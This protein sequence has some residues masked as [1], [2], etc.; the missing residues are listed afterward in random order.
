MSY[1]MNVEQHWHR[2]LRGSWTMEIMEWVI[3]SPPLHLSIYLSVCLSIRLSAC[4]SIYLS[5]HW[6]CTLS[7]IFH[8]KVKVLIYYGFCW[9]TNL[10]LLYMCFLLKVHCIAIVIQ[11]MLNIP[12]IAREYTVSHNPLGDVSW[13]NCICNVIHSLLIGPMRHDCSSLVVNMFWF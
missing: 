13:H 11:W 3:T 2:E 8:S 12:Y 7:C 5:V 10:Q 1:G 9:S 6:V 4:L